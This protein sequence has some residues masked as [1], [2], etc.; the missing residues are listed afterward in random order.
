[1]AVPEDRPRSKSAWIAASILLL[2]LVIWENHEVPSHIEECTGTD[3]RISSLS[4]ASYRWL[5]RLSTALSPND[6]SVH[7]LSLTTGEEPDEILTNVCLQRHFIAKLI[8]K[9]K[10][11]HATVIAID[12]RYSNRACISDP[13][14]D[15]ELLTAAQSDN[16]TKVVIGVEGDV[17]PPAEETMLDHRRVCLRP[18]TH[19]E[20]TNVKYGLIRFDRDI[21]RVPLSWPVVGSTQPFPTLSLTTAE[22]KN[23]SI[24]TRPRLRRILATVENM[25]L[26]A[27]EN[28]FARLYPPGVIEASSAIKALCGKN[29]NAMTKWQDCSAETSEDNPYSGSIIFI[30]DHTTADR[31]ESVSGP[32]Y[33][34]DLHANYVAAILSDQIYTPVGDRVSNAVGAGVWFGIVELILFIKRPLWKAGFVCLA[35]WLFLLICSVVLSHVGYLFMPWLQVVSLGV[36]VVAWAEHALHSAVREH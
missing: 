16:F 33:G 35:L 6:E 3:D 17:V 22:A 29:A 7:V 18:R 25:H 19:L 34:V 32:I 20:F 1:V 10:S 27:A 28:P 11:D 23:P 26:P 4:A 31:H 15:T 30:G 12:K 21:R 13:A 14:A 2:F 5:I 36:A 9:L 8:T 24:R